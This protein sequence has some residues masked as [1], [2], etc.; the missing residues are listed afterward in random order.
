MSLREESN[1]FLI[2]IRLR[3]LKR[4]WWKKRHRIFWSVEIFQ[5]SS[6]HSISVTQ[7]FIKTFTTFTVHRILTLNCLIFFVAYTLIHTPEKNVVVFR[8]SWMKILKIVKRHVLDETYLSSLTTKEKLRKFRF[9]LPQSANEN[10]HQMHTQTKEKEKNIFYNLWSLATQ[11]Y[12]T[13]SFSFD[14]DSL[15]RMKL[16]LWKIYVLSWSF[17]GIFF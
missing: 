5:L 10:F 9:S 2:L 17:C 4:N 3:W 13:V 14:F 8:C 1:S 7:S 6:I 15:T 12:Q 11:F 16:S